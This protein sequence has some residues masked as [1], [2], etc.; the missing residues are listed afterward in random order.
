MYYSC[1]DE[2]I[3]GAGCVVSKHIRS[4]VIFFKSIDIRL[5][6]FTIGGEFKNSRFICAHEQTEGRYERQLD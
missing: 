4:R 6:V 1:D 5:W 3:F 2:H